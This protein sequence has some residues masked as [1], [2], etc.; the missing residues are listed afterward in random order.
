MEFIYKK[1]K[2]SE[3]Y[4]LKGFNLLSVTSRDPS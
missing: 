4:A 1:K 3:I 2:S